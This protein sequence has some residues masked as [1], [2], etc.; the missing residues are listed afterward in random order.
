MFKKGLVYLF[1]INSF[2]AYAQ[3]L[4]EE[5]YNATEAFI[6]DQNY[7]S[8]EVLEREEEVLESKISTKDEH[9]AFVYLQCNK[10]YYLKQINNSKDAI[11]TYE[12]AWS[13]YSNNQ[14]LGYDIIEYCL[15]PLGNLYTISKD[16]T[17][18]ENTTKQYI[19]LAEQ[20][21]NIIQKAAGII[22]LSIL[23]QSL[24]RHKDVLKLTSSA[25]EFSKIDSKQ[26]QKL[27]NINTNSQIAL[28]LI[29]NTK[30]ILL[31]KT[32]SYQY[33]L[34]VSQ[35]ELKNEN[36]IASKKNFATA[37]KI[38]LK[39]QNI[40]ARMLAKF[41]L[42]ES[43]LLLKFDDIEKTEEN[44]FNALQTL[45]PNYTDGNLEEVL[46]AENTFIDIFELL[47]D[48]Q[49]DLNE[50]LK[51]YNLSFYVSSLLS[52]D[53]SSQEAKILNEINN[54]NRSEKCIELLF[55]EYS[56]T[57]NEKFLI[58]AFQYAESSKSTVLKDRVRKK[59]LIQL[60]PKDTLLLEQQKLLQQQES[61]TNSLIN[62]QLTKSRASI[63]NGFSKE[64]SSISV[65]LKIL[66]REVL[67]KHPSVDKSE[68]SI[69][70]LESKL[71]KDNAILIEF[72]YGK[73]AIYQFV[74]G[75]HEN[76]FHK[77]ELNDVN[78]KIILDFI[79]LFDNAS[80]I[81]ND[82]N[83]YI[84]KAVQS[85]ELLNLNKVSDY[86]NLLIIPDGLLNFI[87]FEAM[88]TE[89]VK[90]T[91]FEKM[92]FLM[93]RHSV[94]YNSTI[95]FYLNKHQKKKSKK[96]LGVFPVFENSNRELKYSVEEANAIKDEMRVTLLINDKATKKAFIDSVDDYAIIHLST[97]ANSG[98]FKNPA[99]IDFFDIKMPLNELYSLNLETELVVLSAC[100][101]G[102]GKLQKGEGA[103][104]MARG[105]Q[106]A[107][108]Q[109]VL[110]SL[111]QIN[112]KSTSEIMRLFYKNYSDSES[113]NEANYT[114]KVEYLED[115]SIS[116]IKK[117]PYYW[118]A[119]VYYGNM[120]SPNRQNYWLYFI[121]G[122]IFLIF[123]IKK[124]SHNREKF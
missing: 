8:F 102:V 40:T 91:K 121:I 9:L 28:N 97:H 66:K 109:N 36:I 33:Y 108:A 101:T 110:F 60:Y 37:R 93:R 53:I 23:Y 90:P 74:I 75:A 7:Q 113:V 19:F 107:G 124:T 70:N 86:K 34:S 106:Y 117:S 68:V 45:L 98:D 80:I 82:I 58:T 73:E 95:E 12:D 88:L 25:L 50:T 100:E 64:L 39:Q 83:N 47:G 111:W 72:F 65:K 44:L 67:K 43:Q 14:L 35:F 62:E 104:S 31:A 21:K 1:T 22:N 46:Y 87:P 96:M 52:A 114:S 48:I 85:F 57:L 78:S 27:I 4:E 56:K 11:S 79:H 29:T 24:G 59:S 120:E 71:E 122:F 92:P 32:D 38:F 115:E 54:R 10:A 49:S 30:E 51:Y 16:Y 105:F 63:L 116:N 77:I 42:Y 2:F 99:T 119:F 76:E 94:S 89:H 69:I 81:N 61:V 112:D 3:Q 118:S 5:I 41:Y 17:N 103:M 55:D 123:I 84:H 26:K 15:K 18:A 6:S 20:E 13:R